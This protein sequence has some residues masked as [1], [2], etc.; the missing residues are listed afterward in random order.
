MNIMHRTDCGVFS[1][2]DYAN[3]VIHP[4]TMPLGYHRDVSSPCFQKLLLI[5]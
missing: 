3:S 5:L 1:Y 2:L 4:D